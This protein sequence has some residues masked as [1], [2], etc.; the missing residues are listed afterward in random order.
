MTKKLIIVVAIPFYNEGQSI[1]KTLNSFLKLIRKFPGSYFCLCNNNS[2][3]NSLEEINRFIIANPTI[4]VNLTGETRQGVKY[5]RKT[6][7]EAASSENPDLI[8]GT[9]ADTILNETLV[10]DLEEKLVTFSKSKAE[11]FTGKGMIDEAIYIRR[12]IYFKKYFEIK[13]SLWNLNYRLF[14]PY[15]FGAFFCFKN[16]FYQKISDYYN[17]DEFPIPADL[18]EGE[19]LLLSKRAYYMEGN[20]LSI[21]KSYIITSSRRF[22]AD[23]WSWATGTR[24]KNIRSDI[25]MNIDDWFKQEA[26]KMKRNQALLE[27]ELLMVAADRIWWSY[28]DA[29]HFYHNS[30]RRYPKARES[31]KNVIHFFD[32]ECPNYDPEA[33]EPLYRREVKNALKKYLNL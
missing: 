19:D 21:D 5:A 7:L 17:P 28:L 26:R 8:I 1:I 12:M 22:V 30:G 13:R 20:F 6:S 15:F 2:S 18:D 27:N 33:V 31:L 29:Y 4:K 16:K 32:L 14:G 25:M 24:N 10:D 3:D 11:V 23:P 9:D